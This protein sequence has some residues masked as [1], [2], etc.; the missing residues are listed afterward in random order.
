[1]L[2]LENITKIYETLDLKQKAL[3]NVSINFRKCEFVSILGQSGSGK[4][5]LLNII[6]GLDQ[7]SDGDLLIN[8]ISTKKYNDRDWDVYR[9]H[10]VGFVFQNYNLITHQSVLSNV[11]LALTLS[12]FSK[13]E[14]RK[15]AKKALKDVGLIDHINKKPNQLS[16]GQM[17][18]VAIARALINEPDIILADE[19]T[20]ALDSY[21]SVQ[22]MDLLKDIS[23]NKLVIMVTHNPELAHKYSNR[24]IELKDGKVINDTNEF[25]DDNNHEMLKTKKKSK[26]KNSMSFKT[27]F[28]LSLKN[29]MTKKGRTFLT[30]FAGSIGIIGIAV[31]LSVSTGVNKYISKTEEETLSSYPIS[32]EK[33]TIDFSGFLTAEDDEIVCDENKI[34]SQ[35]M[36]GN[37]IDATSSSVMT[38][39]LAEFKKYLD[40]NAEIKNVTNDVKYKYNF[41]LEVYL[42][43]TDSFIKV[44]PSNFMQ[45]MMG[46]ANVSQ[47]VFRE[48]V[49]ND[50]LLESQYDIL[51]GRMPEAYNEIV[52]IVDKN[53]KLTDYTMY[54]L[55]L[56]DQKELADIKSGNYNNEVVS[57]SYQDILDLDYKLVLNTDYYE[58]SGNVWIDKSSDMNFVNNLV[59]NG[60]D[61]N[62]VGILKPND[63]AAASLNNVIGYNHELVEFIINK[64]SKSAIAVEQ[65]KNSSINVFTNTIFDNVTVNYDMNLQK[66][67]IVSLAEPYSIEIY[68][69]SFED[70]EKIESIINDYNSL[71]K[72]KYDDD[73]TITYTDYVGIIMSSVTSILDVI[74]IVLIG[75]VSVSLVVSSI[76]IAIITYISV[77]ERTKEIGILRAI[78][79]SKR[80][81]AR[82]FNAETL[83]VG[84]GAGAIGILITVLLC[85]PI[86][87]IIRYLSGITNIGASLPVVAAIALVIISMLLTFIAGLFPSKVAAR[88]DPVIALRS[89]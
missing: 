62:I 87:A 37:L 47:S 3:D 39:N 70:K 61:L 63:E 43:K 10:K 27:A 71:V 6:G 24:I 16:G 21:T 38:N 32:I 33:N 65:T 25:K 8:G 12:G 57:Y 20:G 5:T 45:G 13:S 72:D 89:E 34:C 84:F 53:N 48:L 83:I 22:V 15:R 78:G 9:N 77:L 26:K 68:P 75:F 42:K 76:M 59:N 23:K 55:G 36:M 17:Q 4:T 28:E 74:T 35:N 7:Y 66:L 44:N 64:N 58:K 88:K 49:D 2:R 80:D 11:E 82:V 69:K 79:A 60:L 52:L 67:G 18:R 1:M 41:D 50:K 40:D 14:R 51:S 56:K 46:G 31:I 19:P 29:L 81:I 73:R 86:N 54:M 30:A 85:F